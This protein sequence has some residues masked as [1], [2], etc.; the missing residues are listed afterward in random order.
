MG[1]CGAHFCPEDEIPDE[2]VF[3]VLHWDILPQ[4]LREWLVSAYG[5]GEWTFVLHEVKRQLRR[6]ESELASP[7]W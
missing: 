7:P 2:H 6:I 5:T 4:E 1:R 3:C